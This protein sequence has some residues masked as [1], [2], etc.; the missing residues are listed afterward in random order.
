M[1]FN[2]TSGT[3]YAEV[4]QMEGDTKA[5]KFTCAQRAQGNFTEQLPPFVVA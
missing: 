2:L 4:K 3:G 1:F 5:K